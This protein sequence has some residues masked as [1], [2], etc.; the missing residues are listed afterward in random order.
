LYIVANYMS[1]IAY[2][3]KWVMF[4]PPSATTPPSQATKSSS[5]QTAPN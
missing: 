1:K 4:T 3:F 5:L 2:L